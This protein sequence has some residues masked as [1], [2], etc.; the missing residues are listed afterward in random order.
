MGCDLKPLTS[1]VSA[2]LLKQLVET[3]TARSQR[4][5]KR[6]IDAA[7]EGARVECREYLER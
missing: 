7:L 2:R 6:K 3:A 1:P 4:S 5:K